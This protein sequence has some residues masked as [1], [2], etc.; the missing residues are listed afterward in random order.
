MTDYCDLCDQ[1]CS[2][3]ATKPFICDDCL[4]VMRRSLEVVTCDGEWIRVNAPPIE[5][6]P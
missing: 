5:E 2:A 6:K 4:E 1:P 3:P